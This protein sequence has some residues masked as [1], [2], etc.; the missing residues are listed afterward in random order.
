MTRL[1][2]DVS[3]PAV[4]EANAMNSNC[5]FLCVLASFLKHEWMVEQPSTS[6]FFK[7]VKMQQCM[8][9]T[10][11]RRVHV[12]LSKYGHSSLKGTV[13]VG[14]PPWIEALKKGKGDEEVADGQPIQEKKV[15]KNT[16]TIITKSRAGKL[17]VTGKRQALKE[18]QIY[19]PKFALEVVR[20]SWPELFHRAQ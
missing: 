15:R 11:A 18:S 13:L 19:P 16:L 14:T 6:C 7:T 2:G 5:A 9:V 3:I 20:Q 8:E 10:R 4:A 17:G 12:W 1:R